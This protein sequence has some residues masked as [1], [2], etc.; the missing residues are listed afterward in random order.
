MVGGFH[1]ASLPGAVVATEGVAHSENSALGSYPARQVSSHVTGVWE[2]TG[3]TSARQ[4]GVIHDGEELLSVLG[5]HQV[6]VG[7]G[8]H[9]ATSHV[10]VH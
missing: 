10:P 7:K 8:G 2:S 5:W 6:V 3:A 1:T 4:G 9:V